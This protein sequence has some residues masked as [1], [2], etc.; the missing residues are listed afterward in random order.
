MRVKL[1]SEKFDE[2]VKEDGRTETTKMKSIFQVIL[3]FYYKNLILN[4]DLVFLVNQKNSSP[5]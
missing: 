5:L 1:T 3:L 4:K 2:K